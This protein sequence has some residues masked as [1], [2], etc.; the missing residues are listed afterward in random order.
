MLGDKYKLDGEPA[1]LERSITVCTDG[2][3]LVVEDYQQRH[4]LLGRLFQCYKARYELD[5]SV[6]DLEKW[7]PFISKAVAS[8]SDN[9][10][11]KAYI[12]SNCSAAYVE[13]FKKHKSRDALENSIAW[14][15]S[16]LANSRAGDYDATEPGNKVVDYVVFPYTPTIS[17]FLDLSYSIE[18]K[19][20]KI[21]AVAVPSAPATSTI[22]KTLDEVTEVETIA[23]GS[24]FSLVEGNATMEVVLRGMKESNWVHFACHGK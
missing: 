4:W 21:M 24:T 1:T 8:I 14:P 11:D 16:L 19:H 9:H 3:C 12:L 17:T 5:G 15:T 7:G 2:L 10:S 18:N 6:E 20:L 23:S 22:P 13:S